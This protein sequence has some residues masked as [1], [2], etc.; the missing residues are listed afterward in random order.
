MNLKDLSETYRFKTR[1]DECGDLIA[2]GRNGHLYT[3]RGKLLYCLTDDGRKPFKSQRFR[4]SQESRMEG[5]ATCKLQC[6]YEG[7]YE[8]T[9]VTPASIRTFIKLAGIPKRR[10]L[11]DERREKLIASGK[12]YRIKPG[13]GLN[14]GSAS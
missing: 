11:S 10:R 14:A 1:T 12:R 7:I 3:D 9:V 8:L 13:V 5:I 4:S 6:D 2:P